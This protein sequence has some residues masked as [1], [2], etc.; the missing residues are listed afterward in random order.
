MQ[1]ARMPAMTQAALT[2][3]ETLRHIRSDRGLSLAEVSAEAGISV[4][5]LS[6]IE[7]DKQTLDVTLLT[8]LARILRVP[9]AE[10]LGETADGDRTS[11]IRRLARMPAT[12]RARVF[13]DASRSGDVS[14]S[15]VLSMLDVL[16]EEIARLQRTRRSG[17]KRWRARA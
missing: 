9:P 11:V 3:G 15:D 2:I 8:K 16:R 4:A 1:I 13:L 10:L 14:I 5:T 17:G 7:T 12:E 6:R